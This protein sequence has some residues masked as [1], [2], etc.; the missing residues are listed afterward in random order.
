MRYNLDKLA[1]MA[2]VE[3]KQSSRVDA[4]LQKKKATFSLQVDSL[5][6]SLADCEAMMNQMIEAQKFVNR[7]VEAAPQIAIAAAVSDEGTVKM[8]AQMSKTF[9]GARARFGVLYA[10]LRMP[11]LMYS[12]VESS[13]VNFFNRS[14]HKADP[15]RGREM[16]ES[17]K[18]LLESYPS[19][20][21]QGVDY[22]TLVQLV[23]LLPPV[24]NYLTREWNCKLRAHEMVDYVD[25][26]KSVWNEDILHHVLHEIVLRKLAHFVEGWDAFTDEVP[27]HSWIHPWLPLMSNALEQLYPVIVAKFMVALT[28]WDPLDQ[29]AYALLRPW[30]LCFASHQLDNLSQ[31]RVIP[32]LSSLISSQMRL[33]PGKHDYRPVLE[34]VLIWHDFIPPISF[35]KLLTRSLFP[36]VYRNVFQF[37]LQHPSG[38]QVI[39]WY[40][41]FKSCFP[42][43][44]FQNTKVCILFAHLL[45]V[46]LNVIV[47]KRSQFEPEILLVDLFAEERVEATATPHLPL[48][49]PVI[50]TAS[51]LDSTVSFKAMIEAFASE[52][53]ILFLPL[54]HRTTDDGKPIYSFGG[55][56]IYLAN[57]LIYAELTTAKWTMASL[58]HLAQLTAPRTNNADID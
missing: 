50:S 19:G 38:S 34:A 41:G 18:S 17:V 56:P 43:V 15:L 36:R 32:K 42:P 46:L 2:E 54:K 10:Q 44:L 24:R 53:G 5:K 45:D 57:Q 22:W 3:L 29:S 26:W 58:E 13:V 52:R 30:R 55:I 8:M 14:L 11:D 49:K 1:D 39:A 51:S 33:V 37:A 27:L 23:A 7:L 21:E 40:Q 28:D 16:M 48:H 12:M 47:D 25:S 4:Q 6:S 9:S 31:S 35:L 20:S